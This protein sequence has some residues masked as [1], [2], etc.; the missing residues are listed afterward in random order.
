MAPATA[1]PCQRMR[2]CP[3]DPHKLPCRS[4][5]HPHARCM[6]ISLWQDRSSFLVNVKE[7]DCDYALPHD[8]RNA[9]TPLPAV[10]VRQLGQTARGAKIRGADYRLALSANAR[11]SLSDGRPAQPYSCPAP[12]S[13]RGAFIDAPARIFPGRFPVT[14]SLRYIAKSRSAQNSAPAVNLICIALP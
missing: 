8:L 11:R 2:T 4:Q 12:S 13:W 14:S 3:F 9:P 7:D 1:K 5:N 6:G 10:R